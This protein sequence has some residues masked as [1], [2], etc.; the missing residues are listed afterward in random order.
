MI[1]GAGTPYRA[2]YFVTEVLHQ[3][4]RI[5][6]ERP[7][8]AGLKIHTTLNLAMQEHAESVVRKDAQMDVMGHRK[9]Q[10]AL[11]SIDSHSGAVRCLVG[12]RDYAL[13]SFNRAVRPAAF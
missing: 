4:V 11:V 5:L 7:K 2:P 12:G 8:L 13:S 6:G 10:A 1:T 3:L 9:G